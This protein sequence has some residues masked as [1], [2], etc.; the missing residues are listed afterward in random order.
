MCP[1]GS[2]TRGRLTAPPSNETL[3]G[4][5]GVDDGGGR[6][7]RSAEEEKAVWLRGE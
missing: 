7:P 6:D 2:L 1:I 3:P 4:Q 5:N